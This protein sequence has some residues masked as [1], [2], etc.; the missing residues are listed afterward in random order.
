V[1]AGDF[2]QFPSR[3]QTLAWLSEQGFSAP[4]PEVDHVLVRG[5]AASSP[6]RWARERRR[7]NGLLLSD[8]PPLD[9]RIE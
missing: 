4:A 7:V 2:N 8:H 3:S 9:V 6:D 5:A 1:I